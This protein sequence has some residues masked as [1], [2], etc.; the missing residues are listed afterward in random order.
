MLGMAKE[1]SMF[2]QPR[3][4]RRFCSSFAVIVALVTS[5]ALARA[6]T[7]LDDDP[8]PKVTVEDLEGKKEELEKAR[9]GIGIRG[10]FNFIPRGEFE[11][12]VDEAPGGLFEPGF[13][14]D[15]VRRKKDFEL[16]AGIGYD[17]LR[18]DDGMWLEKGDQPPLQSPDFVEFDGFGWISVEML[19]MWHAALHEKV[20]LRYGAGFG[21]GIM[22]GDVLQTDTTCT[23]A[24]TSTCTP[25]TSGA[26]QIRDPADIFPVY[27]IINLRAGLQFRPTEDMAI[28]L[29]IGLRDAFVGGLGVEYFF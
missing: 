12:F 6:Q 16:V 18:T 24:Q 14:I 13:S 17:R 21:L 3:A 25:I 7:V 27:P 2:T 23:G 19:F 10:R 22:L 28:N 1:D 5:S 15:F 20:F 9:L 26:G 4:T 29:D 8:T 11:L